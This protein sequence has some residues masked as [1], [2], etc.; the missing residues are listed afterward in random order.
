MADW[1][2]STEH[3]L[4]A[5]DS[6]MGTLDP[7]LVEALAAD[8]WC[9][10]DQLFDPVLM[11]ELYQ[12]VSQRNDLTPAKVGRHQSLRSHQ[13]IRRDKTGW[14]DG[15]TPAQRAYLARM[16]ALRDRMNRTLYLGLQEFE[17]HFA[18]FDQGD[19]Y[20]THVDALKGQ[21]NRVITSVTYLNPEWQPQWGGE[22]VMYDDSGMEL[23][24][25]VPRGGMTVLFLSEEFPHQVLPALTSR[26]SIAGWFRVNSGLGL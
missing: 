3:K 8:G 24:R 12:E 4:A 16:D 5:G 10:T 22:L 11:A 21:R 25:V 7:I 20:R 6:L 15:K 23:T 26:Y 1:M 2:D 17:A 13:D 9:V 19:F 18:R 14:L